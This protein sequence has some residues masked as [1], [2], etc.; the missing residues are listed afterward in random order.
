[1][2]TSTPGDNGQDQQTDNQK[3]I[4][5]FR[6]AMPYINA[7]RGKTFVIAMSGDAVASEHIHSLIHDIVLLNSLGTRIVIVHGI[8]AQLDQK[9]AEIG[10]TSEFVD[11]LRVTD[12]S[13]LDYAIQA[14]SLVRSRLETK[15]SMGLPNSP[16]HGAKVKVA[17][18]NAVTAKPC[19]I[20]DG[21]DLQ[22][23]GSVRKIDTATLGTLLDIGNVILLS[24]LGFSPTGETFSLAHRNMAAE[25]AI[26]LKA[27]KLITFT[28]DEGVLNARGELQREL[29]PAEAQAIAASTRSSETAA[30]IEANARAVEQGVH[31]A[32]VMSFT[33]DG[34]MLHELFS[35][36][37]TGTMI[38]AQHFE[39]TRE[40]SNEDI[41]A[42]L[43][44]IRPLERDGVLVRRDR[45]KL[46]EEID[47]FTVIERDGL[48]IAVAAL[49]AYAEQKTGEIACIA[50]HIDYRNGARGKLLL[51]TLEEKARASG[52][53]SVF[54]LTTQ[55]E[56]W[57][58]EQGFSAGPLESLPEEKQQFY[59]FQRN[60]R[61]LKKV[62]T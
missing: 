16:M 45:D 50:T 21:V 24:P 27:D 3:L 26:A 35:V 37:G 8:R 34:A 41:P 15:L 62:L 58:V 28:G 40:A 46:E 14:S 20:I 4:H 33:I 57:F 38:Q 43:D 29:N 53:D 11:G 9:L 59:N 31:R 44:I 49:Y 17:S 23:T 60:S 7:H 51:Q 42:I 10:H 52:L 2:S 47:R 48:I 5:W 1:M 30:L 54:V 25:L 55:T 6:Q 32:H 19:G 36:D 18:A 12:Q 61:V 22:L 56:H 13:T 39:T